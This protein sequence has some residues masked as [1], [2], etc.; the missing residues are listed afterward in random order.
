[1]N[2]L[3][4]LRP[5]AFDPFG[6]P[7]GSW[8]EKAAVPARLR[9]AALDTFEP[10]PPAPDGNGAAF[11]VAFEAR[12]LALAA[13]HARIM[14]ATGCRRGEAER[15]AYQVRHEVEPPIKRTRAEWAAIARQKRAVTSPQDAPFSRENGG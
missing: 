12:R 9:A 1:M 14:Q 13:W 11:A 10:L 4:H 5:R 3:A 15:I 2:K 8:R 7:V 6:M